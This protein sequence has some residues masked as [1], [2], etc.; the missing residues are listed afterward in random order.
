MSMRS[1]LWISGGLM[2]CLV[3]CRI[4]LAQAVPLTDTT[5]ARYGE[6]ARKMVE[7]SDWVTPQHDYGVPYLAKPPLAFWLSALAIEIGG[8]SEIAPRVPSLALAVTFC[9]AFFCWLRR[10]FGRAAATAGVVMMSSSLIFFISMGT[11]MTDMILTISAAAALIA[12]WQRYHGGSVITE[13]ILYVSLALGLLTK[14]PL[15]AVL[16]LVPILVWSAWTHRLGPVWRRFAWLRGGLLTLALSAPWY[17]A[18]E[19]RTPGFLEY[20]IGGEHFG[21]FLTPGWSG[22]L[23]G[24]AHDMPLGTI[25][26]FLWISL[27]PWSVILIPA[28]IQSKPSLRT[29]VSLRRDLIVFALAWAMT[30]LLLFT[31]AANIVIPYALPAIPAIMLL[32]VALLSGPPAAD[33][34]LIKWSWFGPLSVAVIGA[35]FAI[36]P[37]LADPYTQKPLI[38]AIRDRHPEGHWPIYYWHERHFSAEYYGRGSTS[39]IED[40]KVIE[41][42][43]DHR[44]AFVLVVENSA[45]SAMPVSARAR[46]EEVGSAGSERV[47]EPVYAAGQRPNPAYVTQPTAFAP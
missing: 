20:F 10:L 5:E 12:F 46:L 45:V 35:L 43:L 34:K 8:A 37:D 9:A 15:A 21:R 29:N 47:F 11:V 13:L 4:W 19:W 42:A 33:L 22:D 41:E 6:I 36:R 28:A 18:A 31:F 17:L 24:R 25:W 3:L 1:A 30:P 39:T 26:I 23:Y 14:G 2:V 7:T 38:E 32:A 40:W 27:L 44:Q 16:V